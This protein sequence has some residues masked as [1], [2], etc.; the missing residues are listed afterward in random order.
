MVRGPRHAVFTTEPDAGSL[1]RSTS[2]ERES[3]DS[4]REQAGQRRGSFSVHIPQDINEQDELQSEETDPFLPS[5]ASP[6]HT[7]IDIVGSPSRPQRRNTRSQSNYGSFNNQNNSDG[8][9]PSPAP[10]YLQL[11]PSIQQALRANPNL[12]RTAS[13]FQLQG[14][15]DDKAGCFEKFRKSEEELKGLKSN[16]REFYETQNEI[17]DGF[18]EV[19]EILDNTRALALT[20]ELAPILPQS[21]PSAEREEAHALKVKFAINVN[22]AVNFF[23]LGSKIMIVLLSSS[24]SLLAST[25]D[26]AMD[27][28]STVIIWGT[29]KIIEQKDWKSAYNWPTGKRKMEPMGVVVFSVFMISSFLQVFIE[30]VQRLMDPHLEPTRIPLIGKIVMVSTI[31]VKLIM[32]VWC[33][34]I[35][36]SSVEALTQ[37]AE[38]DIVFNFFSLLFPWIGELIHWPYLDPLGGALLSI[39]IIV[40]WSQ[41]LLETITKLTGRRASPQEHQRIAYLLTR[42]SPLIKYIQHLSVYHAGDSFIVETDVVLPRNTDL[43]IAHNVA[44]SAQYGLEQLERVERAFVHVDITVNDLS[45]HVPR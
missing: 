44:E 18:A 31:G 19:D 22:F 6:K 39:Y 45:G 40:E 5:T 34:T 15:I 10:R 27:F 3:M 8:S 38:N 28:L 2:R 41:T 21:K 11:D 35:K 24:M 7:A 42:F 43:T 36:N 33:R 26:S 17:L 29:S 14:M 20:G 23:L 32:W 12:T 1:S 37:D 13:V 9:Y 4:L 25:V 16:V 30:S